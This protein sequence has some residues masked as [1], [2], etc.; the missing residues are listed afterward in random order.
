VDPASEQIM[1]AA[2]AALGAV[3]GIASYEAEPMGDPSVFPALHLYEGPT[4][5]IETETGVTRWEMDITVEGFVEA[6]S[7]AGA[8]AARAKLRAD[9][10]RALI[11]HTALTDLVDLIEERDLRVDTPV[12]ASKR[13]LGFAQDFIIQ[14]ATLRGDPATFA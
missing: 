2:D 6:G 13:R 11:G 8:R 10:V 9:V 12:L 14:F 3:P 7:G 5:P 1:A 4:R